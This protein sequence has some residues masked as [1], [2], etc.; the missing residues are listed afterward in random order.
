M[1]LSWDREPRAPRPAALAA[2]FLLTPEVLD[3]RGRP[4]P[5]SA[6]PRRE[7]FRARSDS[8]L[9]PMTGSEPCTSQAVNGVGTNRRPGDL[10]DWA[11]AT[12]RLPPLFRPGT[13]VLIEALGK[14]THRV[15]AVPAGRLG[16]REALHRV[17][18]RRLRTSP[19]GQLGPSL[20]WH[21]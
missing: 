18:A 11:S 20:R 13:R 8:P 2:G 12:S 19:L 10:S 15:R 17:S 5:A 14:P 7:A 21:R 9:P 16:L 3:L 1:E 4:H 6:T